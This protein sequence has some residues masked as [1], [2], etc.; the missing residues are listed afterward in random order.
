MAD[1]PTL[2]KPLP[3]Q[4]QQQVKNAEEA[5]AKIYPVEITPA[6]PVANQEDTPQPLALD[7]MA[8][9]PA[10][11]PPA[12]PPAPQAPPTLEGLQQRFEQLQGA[13]NTLQ[14]KYNAEGQRYRGQIDNLENLIS[15]LGS[16]PPPPKATLPPDADEDVVARVREDFGEETFEALV[17]EAGRRLLPKIREIEERVEGFNKDF[18][19]ARTRASWN[20]RESMEHWLDG[21]LP[22]WRQINYMPE[23]KQW[24]QQVDVFSRQRRSDLLTSA[25]EAN[26]AESA[27]AFFASF[28]REHRAVTAQP[29]AGIPAPPNS[30]IPAPGRPPLDTFAAP[31]TSAAPSPA[32]AGSPLQGKRYTRSDILDLYAQKRRGLWRGR[33]DEWA[34]LES[35]IYAAG[36]E[37]RIDQ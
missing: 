26:D 11:E 3:P 7:G 30:G 36:R 5:H 28:A 31:G 20:A 32:P 13:Y 9:P 23:F 4:I 35:D 14:G 22:A 15:S 6:P 2:V 8:P 16:T 37:G 24:L 27:L 1:T 33:E 25:W 17:S 34:R 29:P 12:Q 18:D 19:T 21:Q 10:P